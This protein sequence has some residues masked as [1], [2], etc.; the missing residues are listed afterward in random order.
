MEMRF[1]R[2]GNLGLME[3]AR[4]GRL[5]DGDVF[6]DQIIKEREEAEVWLR[7]LDVCAKGGKTGSECNSKA[8]EARRQKVTFCW[9]GRLGSNQLTK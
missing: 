6:C 9:A 5:D 2:R 4:C 3:W 7:N 8:E 1:Y